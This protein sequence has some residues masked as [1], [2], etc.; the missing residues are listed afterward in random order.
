MG[1]PTDAER[2]RTDLA[3][4]RDGSPFAA[5]LVMVDEEGG[6]VQ[7]LRQVLGPIPSAADM[8]A[9]LTT[10]DV[11]A[12]AVEHGTAMSELG[13]TVVL[14]PVVDVGAGPAIGD[15]SFSDDPDAVIRFGSALLSGY[16]SVGLV[17]TAKH[18]PGHGSASGDTHLVVARTPPLDELV[19]RDLLPFTALPNAEDV[20]V[21]MSHLV[22]PGLTAEGTPASLDAGAYDYLRTTLGFAGLVMTAALDKAGAGEGGPGPTSSWSRSP[23][24]RQPSR[25]S[26]RRTPTAPSPTPASPPRSTASPRR[27][28]P[29]AERLRRRRPCR[30][31]ST[32]GTERIRGGVVIRHVIV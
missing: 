27:E 7:R 13:I 24:R 8:A 18:F 4:L 10:D 1:E 28:T 2:L 32:R 23:R 22:V 31:R 20:A 11:V 25:R 19:G 29:A 17:A 9:T 5:P 12:L 3:A 16:R 30:R 21:M 14:A 26:S 6:R 15:R